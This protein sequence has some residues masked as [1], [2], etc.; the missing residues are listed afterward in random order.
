MMMKVL[1]T[2]AAGFIGSNLTLK[3]IEL[4]H[5]V[6]CVDNMSSG[7]TQNVRDI[8]EAGAKFFE[9]DYGLAGTTALIARYNFDVVFHLGAIPRV[10]YSVEHPVETTDCNVMST[11][12]LLETCRGHVGRFVFSSSS[13]VVGDIDPSLLPSNEH[14]VRRP[15]SPYAIQKSSVEDFC[16]VYSELHGLDVISL[17]YFNVFGPRQY[18][19]SPYSTVISAWCNALMT[20][21]RLR[22]DGDGTQTRDFCYVDNAVAAN[23]LAAT[24]S[25]RFTGEAVNI[26]HGE[27]RSVNDIL[28]MFT[29][30]FDVDV[31]HAPSRVGDV[32][33]THA[34]ITLARTLFGY[35]PTT[36]FE[37]GLHETWRW[38]NIT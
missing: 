8:V 25:N 29:S 19:D 2:G 9:Y 6:W 7:R 21:R 26:A 28:S 11:I 16:R 27:T 24:A 13:A 34:D 5:D 33:S 37:Q 3:L 15:K 32:Y 23:I 36:S 18:G 35:E 1:V 31:D 38:W 30:R 17:R 14:V 10:L 22:V 12:R 4:G 20:T